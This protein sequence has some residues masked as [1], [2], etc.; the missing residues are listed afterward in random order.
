METSEFS[1]RPSPPFIA[2]SRS[3]TTRGSGSTEPSRGDSSHDVTAGNSDPWATPATL[4]DNLPK[5][6][7]ESFQDSPAQKFSK[8]LSRGTREVGQCRNTVFG[9]QQP[10]EE[11]GD[12]LA[13]KFLELQQGGFHM[14]HRDL[15]Q[16]QETLGEG[17]DSFS[18]KLGKRLVRLSSQ[19]SVLV[20]LLRY[21]TAVLVPSPAEQISVACQTVNEEVHDTFGTVP[22][23]TSSP[24]LAWPE[25]TNSRAP[26]APL[27]SA[28]L[29]KRRS[30]VATRSI[31]TPSKVDR[32]GI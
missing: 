17:I 31:E 29:R 9:C 15:M 8:S 19:M 27:L 25:A 6:E 28:T 30:S 24:P 20:E 23:L 5:E 4:R 10:E 14:L 16:L 3:D 13:S 18:R 1:N 7:E 22:N 21:V 2:T 12:V 11:L 26:T 32:A